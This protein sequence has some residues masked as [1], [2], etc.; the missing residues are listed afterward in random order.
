L[1]AEIASELKSNMGVVVEDPHRVMTDW[2]EGLSMGKNRYEVVLEKDQWVVR[3]G[4][5]ATPPLDS[6]ELAVDAAIRRAKEDAPADVVVHAEDGAIE[7][8]RTYE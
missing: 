7:S 1:K 3:E 6:K 8:E 4:K 2:E 5:R